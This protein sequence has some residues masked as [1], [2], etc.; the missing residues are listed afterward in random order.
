MLDIYR[1]LDGQVI[2]TS[3]LKDEEYSNDKYSRIDGVNT[4][5]YSNHQVC[6]ILSKQH[7]KE[8]LMITSGFEGL[9]L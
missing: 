7:V 5:D 4:M 2:L 9:V 8:F 1:K 6:K 3:T